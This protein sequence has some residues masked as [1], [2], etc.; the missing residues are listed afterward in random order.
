MKWLFKLVVI[1]LFFLFI[2]GG[3]GILRGHLDIRI[4]YL[5]LPGLLY[6]CLL[7]RK[8][9]IKSPFYLSIIFLLYLFLNFI[10]AIFFSVDK[11]ASFF[12][13]LLQL[14]L[15]L[16]FI[17]FYNLPKL[18]EKTTLLIII[19]GGIIFS[20]AYFFW[21]W[22]VVSD[23]QLIK[24]IFSAH[25]HLGDFLGLFL[26]LTLYLFEQSGQ[27]LWLV[28]LLVATPLF[29]TSFSRSA[30]L[31]LFLTVGLV[32][33]FIKPAVKKWI[34]ILAG[35]FLLFLFFSTVKQADKIP[36]MGTTYRF[37]SSHYDIR[38]KD[39]FSQ[40]LDYFDQAKRSIQENPWFGIGPANF[41]YLSKKQIGKA[42]LFSESA[43]NIFIEVAAV[44]GL[45]AGLL[46]LTAVSMI[47]IAGFKNKKIS[48][49]L[50]LYLF[51]NF[52]T[53]YVYQ[54]DSMLVLFFILA[55]I[56]YKEKKNF[57]STNF[58]GMMALLGPVFLW[59]VIT[60]NLFL[61]FNHPDLAI[62]LNPTNKKALQRSIT[63]LIDQNNT[64]EAVYLA[65]YYT[66]IIKT[67]LLGIEFLVK[68]YQDIGRDGWALD[69]YKRTYEDNR[70]LSFYYIKKIYLLT[71]RVEGKERATIFLTK[72]LN[73]YQNNVRPYAIYSNKEIINFCHEI[74]EPVC[75]QMGFW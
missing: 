12:S 20:L 36:I 32:I 18:A 48:F 66:N 44:S 69:L 41:K 70:F 74:E 7:L 30:Y 3:T 52:Q 46:F 9:P 40:R 64:K 1:L 11:Q 26:I 49:Y 67:D 8:K 29:V 15:F 17:F 65:K 53:D 35:V 43:H 56:F 4:C 31:A 24:P 5:F 51:F 58:F 72:V 19:C 14:T 10:S 60:S 13:I 33:L 47:L 23:L 62:I 38:Y 34:L 71:D 39:F 57:R 50:F 45:P 28:L 61:K 75:E 37:F 63:K 73:D 21:P 25:N 55:G 22:P 27:K 16:T 42:W 2:V 6:F 59:L 54:I 68:F